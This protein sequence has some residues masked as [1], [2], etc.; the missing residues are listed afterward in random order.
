LPQKFFENT[1]DHGHGE[2]RIVSAR[3][4]QK[5]SDSTAQWFPLGGGN[6][7]AL[8]SHRIFSDFINSP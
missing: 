7:L 6:L 5:I 8:L 1:R 3:S 2:L 4:C